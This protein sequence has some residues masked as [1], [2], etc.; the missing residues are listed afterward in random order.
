MWYYLLRGDNKLVFF[1]EF[2]TSKLS[3]KIS[4]PS[5]ALAIILLAENFVE[6]E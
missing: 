5:P 1:R 6:L 3:D 4:N 2:A